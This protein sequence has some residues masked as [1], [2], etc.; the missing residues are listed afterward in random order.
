MID[1][2]KAAFQIKTDGLFSYIYDELQE[3]SGGKELSEDQVRKLLKSSANAQKYLDK[4]RQLN[5]ESEISNI[6]LKE[7]VI[8]EL[9]DLGCLEIKGK[10]NENANRL[11]ALEKYGAN[12]KDSAYSIWVGSLA[13]F[14]IFMIHNYF[15]LF[16][17]VYD[18]YPMVIFGSYLLVIVWALRFYF[19][20]MKNHDAKHQIYTSTYAETQKLIQEG[21]KFNCFL[22]KDIFE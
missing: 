9:D 22:K 15:G 5:R 13:V 16:T 7:L 10:I 1:L 3:E 18:S 19:K 20:T 11:R 8:N 6:H 4:Y 12:A 14:V 17:N 21:L 2:R